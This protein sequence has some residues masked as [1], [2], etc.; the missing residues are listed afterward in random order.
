[1]SEPSDI[2]KPAH[3]KV[4]L[5]RWQVRQGKWL[6]RPMT[7]TQALRR[8]KRQL[9]G[10]TEPVVIMPVDLGTPWVPKRKRIKP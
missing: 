6:W 1:M 7:L 10:S 4:P 9:W 2:A 5:R 8:A 3:P